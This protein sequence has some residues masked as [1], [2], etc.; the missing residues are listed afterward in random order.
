MLFV[1]F[2]FLFEPVI[3]AYFLFRKYHVITFL[4]KEF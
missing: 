3:Y 4:L 1:L 2:F